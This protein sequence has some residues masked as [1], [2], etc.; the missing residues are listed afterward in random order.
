M[1]PFDDGAAYGPEAAQDVLSGL[2][3]GTYDAGVDELGPLLDVTGL[4]GIDVNALSSAL[5][6]ARSAYQMTRGR[7]GLRFLF[8]V[9]PYA[10]L[11]GVARGTDMD[12]AC[13][14]LAAMW[15][16]R[17]VMALLRVILLVFVGIPACVLLLSY[18]L[19][20]LSDAFARVVPLTP[21]PLRP[22]ARMFADILG[23]ARTVVDP[24]VGFVMGRLGMVRDS[25]LATG[26]AVREATGNDGQAAVA[27]LTGVVPW[28]GM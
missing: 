3:D 9:N 4:S 15:R 21:E 14:R 5:I 20:T 2:V 11:Y 24:L 1:G 28:L 19:G 8:G 26:D 25:T 22:L 7:H 18:G 23:A 13:R 6:P 27:V 17:R 12:W 16:W 10:E